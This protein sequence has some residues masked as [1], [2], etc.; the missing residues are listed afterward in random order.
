MSSSNPETRNSKLFLMD[1]RF[2]PTE[3][4]SQKCDYSRVFKQGRRVSS[5]GLTAWIL[6]VSSLPASQKSRLGL[7]IA[8]TYGN[9]VHRNRLKRLL[10]EVFRHN[11]SKL[12]A[13]VDMVFSARP[14]LTKPDYHL[15]ERL[16]LQLW[17]SAGLPLI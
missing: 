13:P 1:E 17:T 2:R 3:R 4:L 7:A 6:R 14:T 8:K 15:I 5:G 9:A 10:R 16:V 11:K 12:P